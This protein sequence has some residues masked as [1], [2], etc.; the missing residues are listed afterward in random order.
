VLKPGGSLH[1]LDFG[2]A[3]V[4][5]NGLLARLVH[6]AELMRD[7]TGDRIPTLLREAGFAAAAEI[8]DR[9]TLFGHIAYFRAAR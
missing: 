5:A 6:S 3:A 4:R 7:N 8:A 9:R 1:L 2:G